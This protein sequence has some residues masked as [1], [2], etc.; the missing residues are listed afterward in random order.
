MALIHKIVVDDRAL[1]IAPRRDVFANFFG[2]TSCHVLLGRNGAGKTRL[3]TRIAEL[4]VQPGGESEMLISGA[5]ANQ[6]RWMTA[7]DR[8]EHGLVFFTGLPYRRRLPRRTRVVDASP[9]EQDRGKIGDIDVFHRICADLGMQATL[10]AT[11]GFSRALFSDVL[12]PAVVGSRR[13]GYK[14]GDDATN[15]RIERLLSDY[16]D[17][18]GNVVI[19]NNSPSELQRREVRVQLLAE[20]QRA[21][22]GSPWGSRQRI[23]EL[24]ALEKLALRARDKVRLGA[25]YLFWVGVLTGPEPKGIQAMRADFEE[26]VDR[27]RSYVDAQTRVFQEEDQL[28]FTINSNDEVSQLQQSRAAIQVAWGT[29]SSGM[30]ALINQFSC[31]RSGIEKLHQRGIRNILLL[32]DEGDAF[33]HLDWQRRY[34]E[35]LDRFLSAMK[36]DL[37]LETLQVILTTHSP[38]IATDFPSAM[39]T[40]L[41]DDVTPRHTFAAPLDD[42]A[43][44]SFGTPTIGSFSAKKIDALHASLRDG[45][46]TEADAV[47]LEEIGDLTIQNALRRVAKGSQS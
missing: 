7:V 43:F 3:L 28:L 9:R 2:I 12:L 4:M 27:T 6:G 31:I 46:A 24:A 42:I 8:K 14:F 22:V 13:S 38:V 18:P 36:G 30:Q 16:A 5:R 11:A 20:L 32:I 15:A 21:L 25:S 44:T 47:L 41:D 19:D 39:V 29:L 1:V 33:L 37:N 26:L 17:F 23:V 40:N 34:V 45:N 10:Q 35:L